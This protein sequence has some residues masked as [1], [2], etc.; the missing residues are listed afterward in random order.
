VLW[1]GA[2]LAV[3]LATASRPSTPLKTTQIVLPLGPLPRRPLLMQLNTRVLVNELSATL[4]RTATL[5]DIPDARLD[6]LALTGYHII[7]LLGVWRTGEFGLY[8]SKKLLAQ[9]PCM[10]G[11]SEDAVGSSPFA[12][13]DY[14]VAEDLGGDDA[15]DRLSARIRA[16]RMRVIVD[17]VPNHVAIDHPWIHSHPHF[18]IQSRNFE[19][20]RD[21]TGYFS[22][23]NAHFAF[24]RGLL[25]EPWEDT[26]Q[27]NYGEPEL[28]EE[29][30]R[31]LRKIAGMVDGVRCDV[32]ML[33]EQE[34]LLSTWGS[35]LEPARDPSLQA[36]TEF[37]PRACEEARSVNPHFVF[38]AESYW[39]REKPLM[40][41][42]FD[43]CYDKVLYDRIVQ[44]EA[45][46]VHQLLDLDREYQDKL[47]RF[48]ENHDED[49]IAAVLPNTDQHMAA[50]VLMLTAPGL[51]FVHD[52]QQEGRTRRVSM[53]ITQRLP[54]DQDVQ[55]SDIRPRYKTLLAA[56]GGA[57]LRNG[58]WERCL[59]FQV[60]QGGHHEACQRVIAHMCW[61]PVEGGGP[62]TEAVGKCPTP[63]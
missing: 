2:A 39:E 57:A 50:A 11:F 40:D 6:E 29:M 31:I 62:F 36:T 14:A 30:C 7:Y 38:I 58:G 63:T 22:V 48:I 56:V 43:F 54:L 24:G 32:A 25:W 35:Q 60:H 23:G 16:R 15:L 61:N 41:K 44:G 17:F 52:G 45:E 51:H 37:W 55:A 21:P 42:G 5:D 10:K 19:H 3:T 8:K 4:G 27:L 9:D 46:G 18:I 53:H 26:A 59:T 12:I 1:L 49:R 47:V 33:V 28:R 34:L 20:R 13:T